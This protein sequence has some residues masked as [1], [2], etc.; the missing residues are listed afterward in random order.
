M[1]KPR[2]SGRPSTPRPTRGRI[3]TLF[4]LIIGTIL[5]LF[6]IAANLPQLIKRYPARKKLFITLV[7]LLSLILINLIIIFANLTTAPVLYRQT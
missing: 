6:L 1:K 5:A 7:V 2:P 4:P 3:I